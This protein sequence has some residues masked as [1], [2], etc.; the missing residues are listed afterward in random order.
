MY[1][2]FM[3]VCAGVVCL[4]GSLLMVPISALFYHGVGWLKELSVL[5]E[6]FNYTKELADEHA[7]MAVVAL[8]VAAIVVF[9]ARMFY[10]D[11]KERIRINKNCKRQQQEKAERLAEMKAMNAALHAQNIEGKEETQQE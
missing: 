10:E 2:M 1:F 9:F 11:T 3:L 4:L 7:Q 5:S 6:S 8:D